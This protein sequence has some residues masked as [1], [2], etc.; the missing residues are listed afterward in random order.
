MLVIVAIVLGVLLV[1][2]V[3]AVLVLRSVIGNAV[4]SIDVL[5]G[6]GFST[7]ETYGDDAGLDTLWDACEAEDWSSCDELYWQAPA[8][9][10]YE[11]FGATCG[12]REDD[13]AGGC[14]VLHGESTGAYGDDPALDALWDACDG[15]D[16]ASCDALWDD[17]PIGSEYE[18]F[19]DT[20][21]GD[22]RRGHRDL[23]HGAVD[24]PAGCGGR[25]SLV[26]H[27][28]LGQPGLL[29]GRRGEAF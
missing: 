19:G 3:A 4:N 12:G 16:M 27:L 8:A 6:T 9:T 28:L 20:C 13:S 15:G 25:V 18:T 2:G 22:P 24:A 17:S 29:L 1:L 7:G 11:D 5:D 23:L 26:R 21:G 14:A 10:D